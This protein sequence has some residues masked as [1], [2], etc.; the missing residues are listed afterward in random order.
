[1]KYVTV[2]ESLLVCSFLLLHRE[3]NLN[4]VGQQQ[5]GSS[6][7]ANTAY[8]TAGEVI[9]KCLPLRTFT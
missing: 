2:L 8:M 9:D 1:M 7:T 5:P 6:K 4:E 3:W